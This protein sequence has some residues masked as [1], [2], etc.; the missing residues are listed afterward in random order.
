MFDLTNSWQPIKTAP[1]D[2][3]EIDV[4]EYCHDPKWRPDGH[5]IENGMRYINVKWKDGV[6]MHYSDS[7]TDWAP[8]SNEHYTVSHWMPIFVPRIVWATNT[9]NPLKK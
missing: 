1:R 7:W 6:W 8:V 9:T 3:T 5:G 4:W 2:G